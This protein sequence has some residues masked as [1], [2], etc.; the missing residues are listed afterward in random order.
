VWGTQRNERKNTT[1]GITDNNIIYL[2]RCTEGRRDV[3][4]RVMR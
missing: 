3:E 2:E 4:R 1:R